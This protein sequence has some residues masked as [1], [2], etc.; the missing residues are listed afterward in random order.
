MDEKGLE[1]ILNMEQKGLGTLKLNTE[2][3]W[4]A[5]ISNINQKGLEKNI[6]FKHGTERVRHFEIKY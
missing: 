6:F 3:K 2:Q 4:L 1:K 5:K